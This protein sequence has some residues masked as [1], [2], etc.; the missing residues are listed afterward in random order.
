MRTP[1]AGS[2]TAVARRP[3]ESGDPRPAGPR[4][5]R[6]P[7]GRS[8]PPRVASGAGHRARWRA[9]RRR[10]RSG[11]AP[12]AG[13]FQ[14]SAEKAYSVSAATPSPGAA[15]TV[16][17]TASAPARW[18]ATRGRPRRVAQRPLPSITI[19]T[20]REE[21]CGIKSVLKKNAS[22]LT[23]GVNQRF[24]VVQVALQRAPPGSG[25]PILGLRNPSLERLRA[26]DV[27]RLL[28][29][30]RVHAQIA[31]RRLEQGLELVEAQRLV[32][33][34]RA[35]DAKA[36][37]LVDQPVELGGARTPALALESLLDRLGLPR[38]SLPSHRT[39]E[40]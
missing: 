3:C 34:Q 18:P 14:L 29:P 33:G 17:R 25:E 28:E 6:S 32:D 4:R 21:L 36:H 5:R 39:S 23:G 13:R 9:R 8:S 10:W 1:T 20:C 7:S 19:A 40:Q 15:S 11:A 30:A 38:R 37:A 31:V 12:A 26:S 35:H 22:P 27:L 2:P 16:R 24:H